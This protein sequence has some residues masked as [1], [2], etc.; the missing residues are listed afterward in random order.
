[1]P[2]GFTARGGARGGR[3]GF[4]SRPSQGRGDFKGT[5]APRGAFGGRGRGSS[6][7][8]TPRGGRG[9]AQVA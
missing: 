2:G 3:G 4:D 7:N 8:V 1:M 6:G 5:G 9:G